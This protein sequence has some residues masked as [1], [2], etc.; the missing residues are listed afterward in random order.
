MKK[1]LPVSIFVY[2]CYQNDL[3]SA[4][5]NYDQLV[6]IKIDDY[7]FGFFHGFHYEV[8]PGEIEVLSLNPSYDQ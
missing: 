6:V 2:H 5:M 8:F 3:I 4:S 1:R 7:F